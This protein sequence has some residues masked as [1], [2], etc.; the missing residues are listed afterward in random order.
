MNTSI[1]PHNTRV[2]SA[3][4]TEFF[5]KIEGFKSPILKHFDIAFDNKFEMGYQVYWLEK[6]E[7]GNEPPA[8]TESIFLTYQLNKFPAAPFDLQ[9][10][11]SGLHASTFRI[12]TIHAQNWKESHFKLK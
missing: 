12:F 5:E 11:Q 1:K 7:W 8:L 10:E 6:D 3:V 9:K 2:Q 4:L